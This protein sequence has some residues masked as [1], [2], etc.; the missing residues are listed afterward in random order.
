MSS[1][2]SPGA[3]S[4]ATDHALFSTNGSIKKLFI[5][6]P[7]HQK[8]YLQPCYGKWAKNFAKQATHHNSG[9]GDPLLQKLQAKPQPKQSV[10]KL[11]ADTSNPSTRPPSSP[12]TSHSRY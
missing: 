7:E 1:R 9:A 12:S 6:A 11:K 5:R 8:A 4:S 3:A 10:T 2:H